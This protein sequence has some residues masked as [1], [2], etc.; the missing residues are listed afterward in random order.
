MIIGPYVLSTRFVVVQ[1][2]S[3]YFMFNLDLLTFPKISRYI[4]EHPPNLDFDPYFTNLGLEG[5]V[6]VN[7]YDQ[8]VEGSIANRVLEDTGKARIE[9]EQRGY[10][11]FFQIDMGNPHAYQN[12]VENHY[13]QGT[14]VNEPDGDEE[15]DNKSLMGFLIQ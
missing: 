13:N 11:Q 15:V 3:L 8:S 12:Q 10:F 5:A 9:D 1:S 14:G 7:D 2:A 4:P 6:Y